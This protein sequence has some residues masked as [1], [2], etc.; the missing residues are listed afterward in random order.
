MSAPPGMFRPKPKANPL[1]AR[2]RPA[3]RPAISKVR[4]AEDPAIKLMREQAALKSALQPALNRLHAEKAEN[5]GWSEKA[6]PGCQEF[7]LVTTKKELLEGI[8]YHIMR[9]NKAKGGEKGD[10]WLDVTDQDQFPRPVTLHRRDPRQLPAHKLAQLKDELA[11]GNPA[12]D[13]E[14]ERIRQMKADREAQR[15]LDQAQ[16]AP[17][18]SKNSEAKQKQNKKEKVTTFYSKTT[19]EQKKQSGLRYEETLPWHLEDAEGKAGVWVGSYI[20]GLS[21]LNCGLVIDGNRFRMIPLERFYRFD[22]KPKFNTFTLD[23]AETMMKA[24]KTVKRWVMHDMEKSAIDKEREETRRFLG[25]RPRVKTESA[26][27]RA[28]PRTEREDDRELDMSGDEF[29]DD[30]ETPG[31]EADDEDTKD[32]RTRMRREALGANLFGEGEESKVDEEER[33][34]QL[35]KLKRKMIGK[36]TRKNLMKLE[37]AMDYDAGDSDE[38]N[39]PFTSSSESESETDE[40]KDDTKKEDDQKKPDAKEQGGSGAASK[41][42]STP[43]GK[44]KLPTGNKKGGL[45]RPGSPNLSESSGNESSR[46]K[47]KI[48]KPT[49]V[50]SRSGTPLPGRPK[51]IGGPTSDGEATAGEASDGGLKLKRKI[52]IKSGSGA[53]G[54]PSASRAGSPIPPASQGISPIKG[55]TATPS[56]SPPPQGGPQGRIT[57]AEIIQMINTHPEGI[58]LGEMLRKFLGRVDTPGNITKSEWIAIVKANSVYSQADKLLRPKPA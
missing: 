12:D 29:Q 27:S 55:G 8:R 13:V 21:D 22:E 11:N 2:K 37:H 33:E 30:D 26:T 42:T 7:P 34:Q 4:A 10:G 53:T 1:V 3:V 41:G 24:K 38:E 9:L 15:A 45:K 48:T 50:S 58:K 25:G 32:A 47:I 31:F 51:G 36:K 18:A 46:K 14:A 17:A 23:D 49:A 57:T 5:H 54:T 56:G 44:L 35:E 39:N 43:S 6:P 20:A 28:A 16:I 19:D 52:K 40:K